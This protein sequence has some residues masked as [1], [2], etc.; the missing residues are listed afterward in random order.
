MSENSKIKGPRCTGKSNGPDNCD[1]I[2]TCG[3]D[4][5]LKDGRSTP[6]IE[7]RTKLLGEAMDRHSGGAAWIFSVPPLHASRVKLIEAVAGL[8]PEPRRESPLHNGFHVWLESWDFQ[9]CCWR[10][11]VGSISSGFRTREAAH[12]HASHLWEMERLK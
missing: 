5:W 3:D 4:P 2:N 10:L 12:A 7:L 9:A 6:C 8:V 11:I 1:C